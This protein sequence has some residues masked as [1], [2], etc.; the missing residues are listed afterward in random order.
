MVS[1]SCPLM[2]WICFVAL[3]SFSLADPNEPKFVQDSNVD[4]ANRPETK[5]FVSEEQTKF[6]Q[7]TNSALS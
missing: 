3:C 1:N 5:L 6:Y 2:I 7:E 4:D